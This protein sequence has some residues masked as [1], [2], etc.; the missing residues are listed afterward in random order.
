M[1]NPHAKLVVLD[2]DTAKV[3]V[4]E[5]SIGVHM[6]VETFQH[7]QVSRDFFHSKISTHEQTALEATQPNSSTF[8]H[9]PE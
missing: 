1:R 5:R 6:R 2:A 9:S 3:C 7:S 4:G 8:Q